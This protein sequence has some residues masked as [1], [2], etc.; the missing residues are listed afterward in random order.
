VTWS[1][2]APEE[3][4]GGG[5]GGGSGEDPTRDEVGSLRSALRQALEEIQGL[6]LELDAAEE[7]LQTSSSSGGSGGD[8]DEDDYDDGCERMET[9]ESA[10]AEVPG[11]VHATAAPPPLKSGA[12]ARRSVVSMRVR[13]FEAAAVR[14]AAA[15]GVKAAAAVRRQAQSPL[16]RIL[17]KVSC[18]PSACSSSSFASTKRARRTTTR[19]RTW[20]CFELWRAP[21]PLATTTW[22]WLLLTLPPLLCRQ[23][24]LLR[25]PSRP[26]AA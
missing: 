10:H 23:L 22:T 1:Q 20:P 17:S 18:S 25:Q 8:S 7:L 24:Q 11:E 2:R 3:E 26:P 14:A 4:D 16:P 12:T 9:N 6:R 5:G 21:Q 15:S 13:Q 19:T